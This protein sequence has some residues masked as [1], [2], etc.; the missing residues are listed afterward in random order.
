MTE[1]TAPMPDDRIEEIR[2][3]AAAATKGPWT[4]HRHRPEDDP[5]LVVAIGRRYVMSIGRRE[6]TRQDAAAISLATYMKETETYDLK[7]NDGKGGYRYLTEDEI[8][9]AIREDYLLD[10]WGNDAYDNR[11]FFHDPAPAS[12]QSQ[13]A[14]DA[15]P[16]AVF[17]EH[18][19]QDVDDL[20]A[21]VDRLRRD[22]RMLGA[23]LQVSMRS[24]VMCKHRL[25]TTAE[26]MAE[27]MAECSPGKAAIVAHTGSADEVVEKMVAEGWT[28]DPHIE[29]VA[30]KRIR[31]LTAPAGAVVPADVQSAVDDPD[32]NARDLSCQALAL[33]V[34]PDVQTFYGR[35]V[36]GYAEEMARRTEDHVFGCE[37]IGHTCDESTPDGA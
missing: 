34:D 11:L 19:R 5:N 10:P 12:A 29:Y 7:L 37:A 6:R 20:L 9:Q 32:V 25:A 17:L 13:P 2:A 1:Q 18:S 22:C 31:T 3:R 21:E 28:L 16:N 15:H 8:E 23:A 33:S 24:N 26:E 36:V 30:G 4:W 35:K 27:H 14:D